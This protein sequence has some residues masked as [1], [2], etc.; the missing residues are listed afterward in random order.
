MIGFIVISN[1]AFTQQDPLYSQYMFNLLTI[2]PA[3]AGN[4]EILSTVAL[5]RSNFRN[6]QGTPQ[7]RMLSADWSLPDNRV[8]L[9]LH[10]YN[11]DLVVVNNTGL[12]GA[13]AYYIHMRGGTLSFGLQGGLTRYNLNNDLALHDYNDPVF[14]ADQ[15]KWRFNIGSGFFFHTDKLYMG[16][17]APKIIGQ[18]Q[19]RINEGENIQNQSTHWFMV[20]GYVFDVGPDIKLKPSTLLA[21]VP[22]APP[23]VDINLNTWLHDVV[24][25]GVSYRTGRAFVTMLELQM[26]PQLRA[27]F[28]YD[29]IIGDFNHLN[30]YEIMMRYEFG[31]TKSNLVSPRHF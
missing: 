27:G 1:Q 6:P 4:R 10:L 20:G 23:H 25:L 28:A 31:K 22:G 18:G 2:N 12:F 5:Y 7:T 9:G 14:Q 17:S 15:Q 13:Y 16:L 24:A 19:V 21:I 8:G 11:D 3:Y 29:Y 26:S 30:S